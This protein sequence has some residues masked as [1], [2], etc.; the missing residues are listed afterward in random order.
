NTS[1]NLSVKTAGKLLVVE[2]RHTITDNDTVFLNLTGVSARKYRFEFMAD[3]LYTPGLTAFLQDNY[4]HTSTPLNIDGTTSIDFTIVNIAGSYAANR[5]LVVFSQQGTLPV[6]FTSVKAY[7]KGKD[8]Q[9]EWKVNNE[10][11]IKQ[12]EVEK[13]TSGSLFTNLSVTAPT[14]NGGHSASYQLTDIH[15][16]EGYNY[17][18]IK[19]VDDND[20]I[21][22]STIVKVMISNSEPEI[23]VYPNPVKNGIINLHFNN[24]PAGKYLVRLLNKSGQVILQQQIDHNGSTATEP[25]PL[26]KYIPHGIYQLEIN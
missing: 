20:K 4:L 22:Y 13:S 8:I 3:Q 7:Q 1:E 6:T 23:T 21:A 14:G 17:Y 2:R 5:F 25:I 11:D 16:A 10:L 24:Q 15:P 12:Y 19:S 26:N 18:R 9:V